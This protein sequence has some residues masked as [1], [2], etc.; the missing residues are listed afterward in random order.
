M[1]AR[2]GDSGVRLPGP[3]PRGVI[4]DLDGTLLDAWDIHARCLRAACEAAGIPRPTGA[5]L[6]AAQRGTD[7]GTIAE[8]AGPGLLEDVAAAYDQALAAQLAVGPVRPMPHVPQMLARLDVAG[9]RSGVCTG[10]SRAGAQAMLS[11]SGLSIELLV[12]REDVSAP[13][14]A[15]DGLLAAIAL[16][17]LSADEALFVGD[18]AID[19]SAGLAA[20]VRTVLVGTSAPRLPGVCV[21]ASMAEVAL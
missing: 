13:K 14:P 8:L 4:F 19:V 18:T 9:I 16:L 21:V 5:A 6:R 17:G 2:P 3:A 20:R 11:R 1:T 12:A 10:R 7:L 15:P